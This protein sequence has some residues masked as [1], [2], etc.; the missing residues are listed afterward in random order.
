MKFSQVETPDVSPP[1]TSR[2]IFILKENNNI[3]DN[4]KNVGQGADDAN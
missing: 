4:R 2:W 1:H 3:H